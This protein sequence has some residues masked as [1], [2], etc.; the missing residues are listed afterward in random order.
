MDNYGIRNST[1][2]CYTNTFYKCLIE[3]TNEIEL[4][5]PILEK[6]LIILYSNTINLF[7]PHAFFIY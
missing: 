1:K 5:Q 6:K 4:I 2:I 3:L 7:L